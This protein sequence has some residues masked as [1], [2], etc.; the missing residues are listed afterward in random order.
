[1]LRRSCDLAGSGCGG[2][3]GAATLLGDFRKTHGFFRLDVSMNKLNTSKAG[4]RNI[5]LIFGLVFG[6]GSQILRS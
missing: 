3:C 2:G 4:H 5:F 6:G 1:M